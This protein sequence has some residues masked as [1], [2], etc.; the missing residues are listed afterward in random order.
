M[1]ETSFNLNTKAEILWTNPSP[2][3]GYS[4]TNICTV[5]NHD[6]IIVVLYSSTSL[7]SNYGPDIQ[8][9]IPKGGT[10][11]TTDGVTYY[12]T[13]AFTSTGLVKVKER[14]GTTYRFPMYV[15]GI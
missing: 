1:A 2:F 4:S 11:F 15:I 9:V 3:S 12:T 10:G 7:V 5:T 6:V 8:M 14:V 13:I